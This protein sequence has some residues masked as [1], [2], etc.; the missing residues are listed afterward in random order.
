MIKFACDGC[1]RIK[2]GESW[3]LGLAAEAIGLQSARREVNILSSWGGAANRTPSGG[4]FLLG[5]MQRKIH[6]KAVQ[7]RGG[8]VL[9]TQ[10]GE[11]RRRGL[12]FDP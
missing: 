1:G 2:E 9:E 11:S 7:P 4:A 10:R 5:A 3:V 6:A 12:L 8:L